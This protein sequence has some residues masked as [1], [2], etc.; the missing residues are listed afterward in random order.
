MPRIAQH[1]D[2][3]CFVPA[4]VLGGD[5]ASLGKGAGIALG[6]FAGLSRG[7][8]VAVHRDGVGD[9]VDLVAACLAPAGVLVVLGIL[10][11]L[12]EATQRPHLLAQAAADHAEEVVPL[13][14]LA[15]RAKAAVV[16][17]GEDGLAVGAWNL[18]AEAGGHFFI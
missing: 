3:H 9:V 7:V 18:T 16:I 6:S 13:R 5:A 10:Q 8:V 11:I 2:Q 1:A 15:L 12:A 4:T 17:A 14:R